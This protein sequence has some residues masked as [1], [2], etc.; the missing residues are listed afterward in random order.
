M[1]DFLNE[2]WKNSKQQTKQQFLRP[3][4]WQHY[5]YMS[6]FHTWWTV[7]LKATISRNILRSVLFNYVVSDVNFLW[8]DQS[9]LT[10]I[11]VL[12]QGILNFFK[13]GHRAAGTG[14]I[15][16]FKSPKVPVTFQNCYVVAPQQT[17]LCH[18]TIMFLWLKKL[19]ITIPEMSLNI[20]SHVMGSLCCIKVPTNQ[21]S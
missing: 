9:Y 1:Q 21:T 19:F 3:N 14:S 11:N 6:A 18:Y 2:P 5:H 17:A 13:Y 8:Q 16:W 10:Q 20:Y 12:F 7:I 15:W 4:S